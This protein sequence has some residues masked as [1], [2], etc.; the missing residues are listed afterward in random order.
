MF[1]DG[2]LTF[3]DKKGLEVTT[4]TTFMIFFFPV[5]KY[6]GIMCVDSNPRARVFW[7]SLKDEIQFLHGPNFLTKLLVSPCG[8]R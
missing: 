6:G 3:R 4:M 7:S 2:F 1:L 5:Q 8:F